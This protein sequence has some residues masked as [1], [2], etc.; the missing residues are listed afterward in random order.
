LKRWGAA[1]RGVLVLRQHLRRG[2]RAVQAGRDPDGL[3][4]AA[5]TI[6]PTYCNDTV[7]CVPP[8]PTPEE[9]HQLLRATGRTLAES[10]LQ[11]PPLLVQNVEIHRGFDISK[12][13]TYDSPTNVYLIRRTV[14][15]PGPCMA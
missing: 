12:V 8:A 4:R 13:L 11:H 3:R 15:M 2:L 9:D 5:G 14:M 7:L 10:Y 6:I 1:D